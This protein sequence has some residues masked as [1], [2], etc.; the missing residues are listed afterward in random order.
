[1]AFDFVDV[2]S[3]TNMSAVSVHVVSVDT[4]VAGVLV[5]SVDGSLALAIPTSSTARVTSRKILIIFLFIVSLLLF[6]IIGRFFLKTF[7]VFNR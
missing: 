2:V 6:L 7:I 5:V 4:S 3:S 1:M